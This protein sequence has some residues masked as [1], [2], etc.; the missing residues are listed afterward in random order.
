MNSG[1][2]LCNKVFDRVFHL[3][4]G[5]KN[6]KNVVTYYMNGPYVKIKVLQTCIFF[7]VSTQKKNQVYTMNL[8]TEKKI[9]VCTRPWSSLV[10]EST[11][12]YLPELT[13]YKGLCVVICLLNGHQPKD[14]ALKNVI[15]FHYISPYFGRKSDLSKQSAQSIKIKQTPRVW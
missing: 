8:K 15:F 3:V 1:L 12:I 10:K 9:H 13:S 14:P 6:P 5:F 4:G 11:E 7:Q 2:N